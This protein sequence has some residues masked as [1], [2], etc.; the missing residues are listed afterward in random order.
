M[1][2]ILVVFILLQ[3]A[4]CVSSFAP[5]S[6]VITSLP[7]Q[8]NVVTFPSLRL[9][10]RDNISDD[11]PS[12]S[13]GISKSGKSAEPEEMKRKMKPTSARIGGRRKKSRV[14]REVPTKTDNPKNKFSIFLSN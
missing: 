14:T 12:P 9:A 3:F 5:S 13:E 4:N 1:K 11:D 7:G 8:W 10:G 2:R 6:S